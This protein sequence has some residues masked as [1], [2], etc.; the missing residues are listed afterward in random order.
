MR[1][2]EICGVLV[3]SFTLTSAA[4][5]FKTLLTCSDCTDAGFGWCPKARK[6]GGFANKHCSGG[7]TD[8]VRTP[9]DQEVW[10]E[11]RKARKS[12]A[13]AEAAAAATAANSDGASVL[14]LTADSFAPAL[15]AH[16]NILVE[17][18][19]P[20]CGHCKNLAPEY[21]KAAQTVKSQGSENVMAKFD[22][23][24]SKELAREY[25]VRGYPTMIPFM[26]GE[27]QEK[28]S[29]GRT[30]EAIAEYVAG[31]GSSGAAAAAVKKPASPA[32]KK[33]SETGATAVLELDDDTLSDAIT[34]NEFLMVEF[35]A[36]WC[37]HCKNLAPE[38]EKAAMMMD[39]KSSKAK[40]AKVDATAAPLAREE[41][42]VTGFPTMKVFKGGK[43]H[44]EKYKGARTAI[45]IANYMHRLAGESETATQELM[46]EGLVL[47]MT[48]STAGNFMKHDIKN[49]I[50][51]CADFSVD[52]T[53]LMDDMAEAAE[54]LGGQFLFAYLDSTNPE[55]QKIV[56]RVGGTLDDCPMLRM[57]SLSDGFKIYQPKSRYRSK[58]TMDKKGL[59]SFAGAWSAGQLKRY[60]RSE[61]IPAPTRG[62]KVLD[63]VGHT[64]DPMV[65]DS[66][67]DVLLFIY[68]SGC[69]YCKA[70]GTHFDHVAKEMS[71]DTL[72]FAKMNG[73]R[74]DMDHPGIGKR[75]SYPNVLLFPAD[76]KMNPIK[77]EDTHGEEATD[78]LMEFLS[79]YG[80][81]N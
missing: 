28:Y 10:N 59:M 42:G 61:P 51:I 63:I 37:G 9:E 33:A 52:Q 17:F 72:T 57:A 60:L 32:N 20:W 19:A 39:S 5:D 65:I 78:A 25:G 81:G 14:A 27:A 24:T 80:T 35:Y 71:S 49:Q 2:T 48:W 66:D 67:Q 76:D 55:N 64:F 56:S 29:G 54:D 12:A 44:E 15:K 73:P 6:C 74:N 36:P 18:Y 53:E 1:F 45:S 69:Q 22:A 3:L 58:Y 34:E 26:N 13:K 79:I 50:L 8:T 11:A 30:A 7:E 62:A 70:F 46:N 77:F 68:M 41:Y 21:E 31:M 23:T 40:L 47:E 38:Y 75:G 4:A 16:K 43:I